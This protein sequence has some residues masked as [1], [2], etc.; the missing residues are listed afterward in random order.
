MVRLKSRKSKRTQN[1][2]CVEEILDKFQDFRFLGGFIFILL[3]IF[4]TIFRNIFRISI[5]YDLSLFFK[6]NKQ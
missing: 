4:H 5:K 2:I 3:I 1:V 6:F